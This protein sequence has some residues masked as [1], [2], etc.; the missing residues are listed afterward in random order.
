MTNKMQS[1]QQAYFMEDNFASCISLGSSCKTASCLGKIGLRFFSGPFDWITSLIQSV[2]ELMENDFKNF[3]TQEN[4]SMNPESPTHFYDSRYNLCFNHDIKKNLY[5]EYNEVFQKYQRRI[6][7]FRDAVSKPTVFFRIVLNDDEIS[8]IKGNR[9]YID[10][11]I[12]S[13][14]SRNRIIFCLIEGTVNEKLAN[15]F[16]IRPIEHRD[17][18]NQSWQELRNGKL[19]NCSYA[20]YA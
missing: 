11:V 20:A 6:C 13:G 2:L 18:C 8:W 9:A 15:S 16:L 7:M 19:Y 14:N 4:L 12:R 5:D 10:S 3:L 17:M 1:K